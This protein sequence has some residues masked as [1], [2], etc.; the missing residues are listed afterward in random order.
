MPMDATTNT[1]AALVSPLTRLRLWRIRPAPR[2]P[3]PCTMFEATRPLSGL[4]SPAST[5]DSSVKNAAPIQMSRL[6]RTPAAL[7][8]TS[9]SSPMSPPSRQATS[10]RPTAPLA[11]PTCCSQLKLKGCANCASSVVMEE[12]PCPMLSPHRRRCFRLRGG[13]GTK[14]IGDVNR[15][16]IT[17]WRSEAPN[18]RQT[19]RMRLHSP[20]NFAAVKCYDDGNMGSGRGKCGLV[21]LHVASIDRMSQRDPAERHQVWINRCFHQNSAA[22][23]CS[24]KG[25]QNRRNLLLVVPPRLDVLCALDIDQRPLAKH[26]HNIQKQQSEQHCRRILRPSR[27]E[28]AHRGQNEVCSKTQ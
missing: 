19:F 28:F 23:T 16:G 18:H 10:S 3:I 4:A 11:T 2:K 21:E 22:R 7:R 1:L 13:R 20:G 6:V 26:H 9:R 27:F 5:A 8:L 17:A 24:E 14:G 12:F 25:P 15:T